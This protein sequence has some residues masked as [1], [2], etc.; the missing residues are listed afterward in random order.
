VPDPESLEG[1]LERAEY[2]LVSGL[3]RTVERPSRRVEVQVAR[4]ETAIERIFARRQSRMAAVD[5]RLESAMGRLLR[6]REDRLGALA[7]RLE[8]LSPLAALKRGY[9]VPLGENGRLLRNVRDFEPGSDFRLRI[10][11]GSINCKVESVQPE[12]QE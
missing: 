1:L 7:G 9:A 6:R 2:R 10:A 5:G 8:A 11:D 4:M 12:E 3:R